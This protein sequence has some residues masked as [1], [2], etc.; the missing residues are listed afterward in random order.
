MNEQRF[1]ETPDDNYYLVVFTSQHSHDL[2]NYSAVAN[3]LEE[4]ASSQPGFLGIESVRDASG[5]GITISYWE[6]LEYIARWKND[7]IHLL[8]QDLGKTKWY[9][10]FIVRIAKIER[11][12][13]S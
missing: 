2:E 3:K 1:A 8:A 13:G 4:I 10:R 11:A 6:S 7:A 5:F 9:R 12:Y